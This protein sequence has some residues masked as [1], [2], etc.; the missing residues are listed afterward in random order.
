[1]IG[2]FKFFIMDIVYI[3]KEP[4]L[5]SLE[6][7]LS[8]RSIEKNLVHN[9][10]F[11]LGESIPKW[12]QN[13]EFHKVKNI[14]AGKMLN[15]SNAFYN[16]TSIENLSEDFYL[17]WDDCYILNPIETIPNY[18]VNTLEKTMKTR[19]EG[20]HKNSIRKVY[21]EIPDG[22]DCEIHYPYIYNK[23]KLKELFNVFD[24]K[25]GYAMRSLYVSYFKIDSTQHTDFKIW[26]LDDFKLILEKK[27]NF[28][29]TPN[30]LM[31]NNY[32]YKTIKK[33]FKDKSKYE[34]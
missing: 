3:F 22:L 18:H 5:N 11:I 9:K 1:M 19:S 2:S 23:S 31:K 26:S 30:I 14:G 33:L 12:I 24:Y 8:L 32:F 10:V 28:C 25:K 17:F 34:K 16:L 7:K 4:D 15:I 27:E 6:L 13:I 29:S 20:W 21:E